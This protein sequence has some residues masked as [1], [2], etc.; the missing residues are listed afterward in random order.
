MSTYT[1]RDLYNI[2]LKALPGYRY[3]YETWKR[4]KMIIALTPD[5]FPSDKPAN[6]FYPS[7]LS[8]EAPFVL[9]TR[10]YAWS[11][12]NDGAKATQYL[13]HNANDLSEASL[14]LWYEDSLALS[15]NAAAVQQFMVNESVLSQ[16][17]VSQTAP[18][19]DGLQM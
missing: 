6:I 18:A 4:E 16:K 14:S 7:K 10:H 9:S 12:Q 8:I 15:S 19:L 3:S 13:Q 1:Y 2:L 5:C 11:T 17:P